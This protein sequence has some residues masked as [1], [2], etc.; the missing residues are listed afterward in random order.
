MT[1]LVNAFFEGMKPPEEQ[2]LNKKAI[3]QGIGYFDSMKPQ[4]TDPTRW[5]QFRLDM[6]G[7]GFPEDWLPD[8]FES[9]EQMAEFISH[10]DRVNSQLK[11]KYL[12]GPQGDYPLRRR[13]Q[14]PTR[15]SGGAV[16]KPVKEF[17][18]AVN[19]SFKWGVAPPRSPDPADMQE[20]KAKVSPWLEQRKIRDREGAPTIS[21]VDRLR[22]TWEI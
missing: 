5:P 21:G 9:P 20:W 6:V 13:D 3:M 17:Q 14:L 11:Q 16:Y 4:L 1:G 18:F 7:L 22:P 12:A 15:P 19:D 2:N 10:A 8:S